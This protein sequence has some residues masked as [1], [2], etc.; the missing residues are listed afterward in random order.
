MDFR[1]LFI[2][3][4]LSSAACFAQDPG[5]LGSIVTPDRAISPTNQTLTGAWAAVSRRAAPPGSPIPPPAPVFLVFHSDGTLT[6]SGS[7]ADSAFSGV[8]IRIAD[9]KFLATYVVFNYDEAR[10]VVSI[11]KIRLTTQM[12]VDGSALHGY[13]EVLVVDPDGKVLFT[14]LGGTHSMVRVAAERPADF[15]AFLAKE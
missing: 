7:G 15:D 13:Q 12:D 3:A 1:S 5:L 8:W 10:T 6:G 2:C 9:R 14:A 11:A 4:A